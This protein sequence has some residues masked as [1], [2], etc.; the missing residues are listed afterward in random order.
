MMPAQRPQDIADRRRDRQ[1]DALVVLAELDNL[2]RAPIDFGPAQE[3]LVEPPAARLREGEERRIVIAHHG[4][5]LVRF[6]VG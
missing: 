2:A 4:V 6:V 1:V 3:A 5:D